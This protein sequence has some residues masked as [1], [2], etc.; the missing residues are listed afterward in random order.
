MERTQAALLA[1]FAPEARVRRVRWSEGETQILELGRGA[2][3][4]Y[5]HGGLGGAFEVVPILAALG[6]HHRVLAVDRPGHGLADPFD[7]RRI[8]LLDH[9]RTFLREILDAVDLET[10]DVL[11]NSLGAFVSVAFAIDA[12]SRVSRLALVG[13]P[14]GIARRPP[15]L[16]LPFGLPI[17]G[18]RLG[19]YVFSNA[20]REGNRKFWGQLLV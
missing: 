7:Y 10:V 3:L 4:L 12:P 20:T 16:M 9:A 6:K 17:V 18:P 15:L 19:R 2:P 14:F 8:D 13:A 11:A 5:V 1:R